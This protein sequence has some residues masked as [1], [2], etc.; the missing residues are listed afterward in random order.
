MISW[1]VHRSEL[2]ASFFV[3]WTSDPPNLSRTQ[4]ERF[5]FRKFIIIVTKDGK[6]AAIDPSENGRVQ[7]TTRIP[8]LKAT[9][10]H[11]EVHISIQGDI[12]A[13]RF[14]NYYTVFLD[15]NSGANIDST[16]GENWQIQEHL[17]KA[18]EWPVS[19]LTHD[20]SSNGEFLELPLGDRSLI[21]SKT[22]N[23][24][25]VA[26]P[27]SLGKKKA[28][29]WEFAPPARETIV[30][31]AHRP[32]HDPVA[33][34]GK[35]LGDRN[36]LY[37]Y[38]NPNILLVTCQ[39]GQTQRV[40]FVL[41]DASTGEILHSAG[42]SSV[43]LKQ[44]ISSALSGN[45][46]AYS[47]YS[48][49]SEKS[50]PNEPQV[51]S[52]FQLSVSELYES[53]YPNDRRVSATTH[54]SSSPKGNVSRHQ[55]PDLPY[56]YTQ[57]FLPS[58][59]IAQ[60]VFITTLQGI[61]PRSLLCSL[62]QSNSIVSIPRYLLDPRRPSGREPNVSE[63]EEG[64]LRYNA[65]LEF[66]PTWYLSHQRE[67]Y[68]LAK[69]ITSPSLLESTSLVFAFG[70][71]DLFGT[72]V[73]PIGG[74]DLLGKGFSKIQLVATVSA[75]AIGTAI[76]SPLVSPYNTIPLSMLSCAQIRRKQVDGTWKI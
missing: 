49:G 71:F 21:V 54:I 48:S 5:G 56:V 47:L 31:F 11:D 44:P 13:I 75:L 20:G 52:G 68:S 51:P 17:H 23:G 39:D 32:A 42:R 6:A 46:L 7:W 12:V 27:S 29:A 33:S 63:I 16:S 22:S 53:P 41:L 45:I 38:L 2:L 76:L 72:R 28:L 14:K 19:V 70:D 57:S 36:V 8:S 55:V 3:K 1:A 18:S 35:V 65:V 64:L 74:F 25:L 10:S 30:S 73:S 24:H 15:V 61:T 26:R 59:P 62:P 67:T 60:P 58:E 40:S 37:K 50:F 34:I 43:N 66:S 9:L 69:I 4:N